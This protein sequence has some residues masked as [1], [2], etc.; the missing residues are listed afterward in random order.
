M[1]DLISL[2]FR[3]SGL[4]STLPRP[5]SR[6]TLKE[7]Q[8]TSSGKE[9]SSRDSATVLIFASLLSC[10][11]KHFVAIWRRWSSEGPAYLASGLCLACVAVVCNVQDSQE[12][13]PA[14]KKQ[15]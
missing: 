15:M 10:G 11:M 8:A 13:R 14:R 9:I 1:T 12:L 3:S 5:H 2:K 4:F 7:G 6:A